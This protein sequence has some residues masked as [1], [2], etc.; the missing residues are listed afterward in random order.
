VP[1]FKLS[2]PML[3]LAGLLGPGGQP[4]AKRIPAGAEPL[5]PVLVVEGRPDPSLATVIQEAADRLHAVICAVDDLADLSRD[6]DLDA[7]VGVVLTRPRAPR[8]WHCA[9]HDAHQIVGRVPVAVL[10]PQPTSLTLE[11]ALP[12]DPAFI[13]P[14]MTADRLLYA[15]GLGSG[16]R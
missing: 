13:A 11:A 3:S 12:I 9:I 6:P 14:P 8:D 10:A 16:T 7:V 1:T 5:P 2:A 15:L 4:K